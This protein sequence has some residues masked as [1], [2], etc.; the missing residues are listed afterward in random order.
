[1]LK[2]LRLVRVA[3]RHQRVRQQVV[4]AKELVPV[5]R[6]VQVSKVDNYLSSCVYLSFAASRTLLALST[7]Q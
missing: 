6:F 5:T 4:V 7:K 2:K 1:V 3:V